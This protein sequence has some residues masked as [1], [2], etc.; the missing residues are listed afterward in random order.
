MINDLRKSASEVQ[1]KQ[2]CF[3]AICGKCC[4]VEQTIHMRINPLFPI[5][6]AAGKTDCRGQWSWSSDC[7]SH[8]AHPPSRLDSSKLHWSAIQ[9]PTRSSSIRPRHSLA[10]M[11]AVVWTEKPAR[12][13]PPLSQAPVLNQQRRAGSDTLG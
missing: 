12:S 9:I 13:E 3:P 4:Q 7:S 10:G 1:V 2:A 8:P 11:R 5:L 6:A